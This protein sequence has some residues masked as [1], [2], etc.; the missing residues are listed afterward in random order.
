[1][2][3][4]KIDSLK[5]YAELPGNCLVKVGA[6]SFVWPGGYAFN[7]ERLRETFDEVQLLFLEPLEKSPISSKEVE[8]LAT[9][10]GDSLS[11]SVHLPVP[12][13]LG[14]GGM[15]A[16]SIIEIIKITKPLDVGSF[17]LHLEGEMNGFNASL[18]VSQIDAIIKMSGILSEKLCL[19]NVDSSFDFAWEAV[20]E[21]GMSI[22]FD[23]GHIAR[24]GGDL[25]AFVERY[26]QWIRMAHI[27]GVDDRDHK[28]IS[29]LEDGLVKK[30]FEKLSA[31][32]MRGAVIIENYSVDDM[33]ISLEYLS[34]IHSGD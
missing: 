31:F 6:P 21:T 10:A 28:P 26:G 4:G 7:V 34:K 25:L 30:I 1:M 20:K 15:G 23:A 19:E 22:C 33:L 16:S 17:V 5:G 18:A 11:Y 32:N 12:S 8:E 24:D 2:D 29:N 27:H 9:L 14:F 3:V 13:L